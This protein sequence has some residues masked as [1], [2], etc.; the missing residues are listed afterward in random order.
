M[1]LL[2]VHHADYGYFQLAGVP[3]DT[4]DNGCSWGV[5]VWDGTNYGVVLYVCPERLRPID[6]GARALL[7]VNYPLKLSSHS[8]AA[9]ERAINQRRFREFTKNANAQPEGSMR[10][11]QLETFD[12]LLA[13]FAANFSQSDPD[14]MKRARRKLR[15]FVRGLIED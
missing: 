7:H 1:S 3:G 12:A 9:A 14:A 2:R 4:D 5:A 10:A 13:E 15:A 11:R 6:R 8:I